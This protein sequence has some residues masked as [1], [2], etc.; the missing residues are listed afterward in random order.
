MAGR[1]SWRDVR[2]RTIE[3]R[4]GADARVEASRKALELE[5]GLAQLRELRGASQVL[6]AQAL[7]V[8]QPNISRIEREDDLR[9]STLERYVE[10]LGGQLEIR[11][12][13][14]DAVVTLSPPGL[15]NVQTT[16]VETK[17]RKSSRRVSTTSRS[18]AGRS[19]GQTKRTT[20]PKRAKTATMK[21]RSSP[22]RKQARSRSASEATPRPLVRRS[23][24]GYGARF[25]SRRGARNV[26]R[27]QLDRDE[28]RRP[29]G[30][31]P[32]DPPRQRRLR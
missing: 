16:I 5:V 31:L 18:K 13:F 30:G 17:G 29:R 7:S 9:V 8:S 20:T 11:A 14:P 12:S 24:I 26:E 23:E 28:S 4:R 15:E 32:G 2:A 6:L 21:T 10:A 1:T 27:A 25:V 3:S 19:A 22:K